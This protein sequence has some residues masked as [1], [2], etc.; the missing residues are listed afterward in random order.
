MLTYTQHMLTYTQHMH[1]DT[2]H[3]HGDTHTHTELNS[4]T[5]THLA[6]SCI[7]Q[8][9]R[10]SSSRASHFFCSAYTSN[11]HTRVTCH[12]LNLLCTATHFKFF[13]CPTHNSFHLIHS[14]TDVSQVFHFPQAPQLHTLPLGDTLPLTKHTQHLHF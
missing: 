13:L 11:K 5:H 9:L 2:Q 12:S 4:Q 14:I 10:T 1:G 8:P 6:S 7:S 3:M